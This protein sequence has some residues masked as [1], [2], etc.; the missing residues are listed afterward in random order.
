MGHGEERRP[1]VEA[2]PGEID[3]T[4]LAA[5]EGLLLHHGDVESG[6]REPNG[7]LH[8]AEARSHDDDAPVHLRYLTGM[9]WR[10]AAYAMPQSPSIERL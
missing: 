9:I 7:G 4:G 6:V 5:G 8:P 1:G 10:K 2:K 3:R